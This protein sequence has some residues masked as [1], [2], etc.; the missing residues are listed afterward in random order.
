MNDH[1]DHAGV[2]DMRR[3]PWSW[4]DNAIIHRYG[5]SIGPYGIAVYMAL[6]TYADK[7][8]TCFPSLQTLSTIL[9][10]NKKTVLKS[11]KRLEDCGLVRIEHR[12]RQREDG[13][14]EC[15]ANRYT[16]VDPDDA[17]PAS[18]RRADHDR[19]VNAAMASVH[20]TPP[21][22]PDTT[23]RVRGTT[24]GSLS[25]PTPRVPD[26]PELEP[27]N[28]NHLS[29]Q[30][31]LTIKKNNPPLPPL[32]GGNSGGVHH[33][34]I[35]H[36]VGHAGGNGYHGPLWERFDRFWHAY[37]RKIGKGAARQA[38]KRLKPDEALLAQMLAAIDQQQG[39]VQW[40]RDGGQYIPLPSTWL[41]QERWE[42]ELPT[43]LDAMNRVDAEEDDA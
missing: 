43:Y 31:H 37:P 17:Q 1:S 42:D 4:F 30:N 29:N 3:R 21:R 10:I 8:R 40:N 14:S 15:L 35:T 36:H 33:S 22:G 28:Q 7:R 39:S 23:P 9:K 11:L 12:Y 27:L 20:G 6:L 18:P 5:A 34:D 25:G 13:R 26:T 16:I 38:W 2:N 19:D 24:G 41:K 32:T